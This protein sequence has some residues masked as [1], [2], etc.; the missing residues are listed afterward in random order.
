[1]RWSMK[2]VRV[3][4]IGMA[5]FAQATI[6]ASASTEKPVHGGT[7]VYPIH[8]GEPATFDCH[9]ATSANV[10]WRVAPH[11]SSLLRMSADRYPEVEPDLA[12]RWKISDDG[13][14]YEFELHSNVKFHD[15]STLTSRD[16]KVSYDRI[17][18]PP[19]GVVSLRA[20]AFEDIKSIEA[21]TASTVVFHLH[22]PNAVMLQLLAMPYA[23]V[24]SADLL[25]KDPS[26]P[27]KRVMGTGPFRFVRYVP[28]TEWVGERFEHYFRSPMPYLAG[29]RALSVAGTAATN[30]VIAGQ[31]H[32]NMRGLVSSDVNRVLASRGDAVRVVGKGVATG[33]RQWLAVN[34]E[35]KPFDD[36]RVRK[37]MLLAMDRWNGAKALEQVTAIHVLGGLVRPGSPLARTTEELEKLPGF[38]RDIEAS[39]EQA[40]RLLAEAGQQ[41]LKVVLVNRREYPWYGVYVTEQLRQVGITVIHQ[42]GSSQ[43][44]NARRKSGDYDIVV[45]APEEYLDDPTIQLAYFKP[46][47]DNPNNLSRA[48][49]EKVLKLYEEQKVLQDVS[50]RRAKVMELEEYILQQAYVLPLFW[51][52]WTRTISNDLQGLDALPSNFLKLDLSDIWLRSGAAGKP[53]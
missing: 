21:P 10:M 18:N 36:V 23:C 47:R 28:G 50:A 16:V 32:Y 4:M 8:L 20:Y 31:V 1:M 17:W 49:D 39:R 43:E 46:F 51:Q 19:P 22:R 5:V 45:N 3:A 12:K 15:G 9:Q 27:G 6:S 29:F 48:N 40:R 13:L 38:S 30:A 41:D 14:T 52:N 53:N 2:T 11:Y 24:Y 42:M 35:R 33:V 26:Y 37:A 25:E 7:L 34:T 44:V